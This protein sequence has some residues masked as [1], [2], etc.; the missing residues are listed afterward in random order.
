MA[1]F[2]VFRG[3]AWRVATEV[4]CVHLNKNKSLNRMES[5]HDVKTVLIWVFVNV[6]F[7]LLI[8]IM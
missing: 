1:A 6:P 3:V 8:V 2:V 7:Y 5:Y 4:L